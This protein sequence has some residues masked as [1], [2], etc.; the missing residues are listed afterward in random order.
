VLD[1]QQ[2]RTTRFG[3]IDPEGRTRQSAQK[4][5][6]TE[7]RQRAMPGWPHGEAEAEA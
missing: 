6:A 2:Q 5:L 1:Q 7:T 3:R 4:L